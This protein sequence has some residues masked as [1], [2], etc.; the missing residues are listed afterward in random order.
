MKE[1]KKVALVA[2]DNMKRDLAEW[3]DWNWEILLRHHLVCT[4]TT[5]K[6][7]TRTL[8]ERGG[9]EEIAHFD[10]TLLKSG[11]L[12]GDQ[13]LGSMIA[14]G[15]ISALIFFWDPMSAQPHDVDVK[16]LLRIATLYNVPTAIN[17]SSADF[18]ISSPLFEHDDYRPVVKD[19]TSYIE[20]V[21]K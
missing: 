1:K 21:L 10:I 19:Y 9:A 15:E 13:Q 2:H 14:D 16:A 18:L 11:P 17:R 8:T 20:R 6:M 4:G 5:G 12:G 3:V 7:V